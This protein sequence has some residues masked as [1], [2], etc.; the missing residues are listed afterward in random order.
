VQHANTTAHIPIYDWFH[1]S[2]NACGFRGSVQQ[3]R[4]VLGKA[5]NSGMRHKPRAAS[6]QSIDA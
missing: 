3:L 2:G 1:M 5:G 6:H 4:E